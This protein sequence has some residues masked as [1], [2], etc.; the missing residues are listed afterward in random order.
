MNSVYGYKD[1]DFFW[2]NKE[3]REF[4]ADRDCYRD[5][6]MRKKKKICLFFLFFRGKVLIFA[7][8]KTILIS[9]NVRTD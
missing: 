7:Q 8:I 1:M 3:N 9:Y 5:S 6:I 2:E 4:F